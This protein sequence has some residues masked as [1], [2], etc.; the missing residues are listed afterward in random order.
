MAVVSVDI[1][2]L[3]GWSFTSGF[4]DPY[5]K[6]LAGDRTFHI[7]D[8]S[9]EHGS[10]EGLEHLL[11]YL[12][13][14]T[15]IVGWSLGGMLAI[16]LASIAEARGVKFSSL[17]CL[18]AAPVFVGS[19]T[20]FQGMSHEA[21]AQ[22]EAMAKNPDELV[23]Q[24][25]FLITQGAQDQRKLLREVRAA[26]GTH[27]QAVGLRDSSFVLLR[28]LDVNEE[29]EGLNAAIL[30][31]FGEQDSLISKHYVEQLRSRWASKENIELVLVPGVS[32]F[33]FVAA[34]AE[35]LR[36]PLVCWSD[37]EGNMAIRDASVK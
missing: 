26:Y 21:F 13:R 5:I 8:I 4:I 15:V 1:L 34:V 17:V 29:L 20:T 31:V 27:V 25:P 32:H 9:D 11:A 10:V 12:K 30:F 7:E 14:G 37:C 35:L 23:K 16:R 28:D 36:A 3:N 6:Q 18:A 33:P 24:F 2:F 19:E 22:F